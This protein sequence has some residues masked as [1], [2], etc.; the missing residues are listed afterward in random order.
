[1]QAVYSA[2]LP[3]SPLVLFQHQTVTGSAEYFLKTGKLCWRQ[4]NREKRTCLRPAQQQ[5]R[6]SSEGGNEGKGGEGQQQVAEV[7]SLPYVGASANTYIDSPNS[8]AYTRSTG[9]WQRRNVLIK[10]II[11][12]QQ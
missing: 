12:F 2:V 1:M 3:S 9:I 7:I 4:E 5:G 8:A 6:V 10:G 11:V